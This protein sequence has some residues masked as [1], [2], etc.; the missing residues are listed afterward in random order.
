MVKKVG[1][2]KRNKRLQSNMMKPYVD[3]I[4]LSHA[5]AEANEEDLIQADNAESDAYKAN[6]RFN[7]TN[8]TTVPANI[9]R[10][11]DPSK[12][13]GVG[14]KTKT[15]NLG[16]GLQGKA[17]KG[18]LGTAKEMKKA[19]LY[20]SDG[21][22]I[23]DAD[24]SRPLKQNAFKKQQENF[25]NIARLMNTSEYYEVDPLVARNMQESDALSVTDAEFK[26]PFQR[27][28]F[29]TK[30][31]TEIGTITG[32]LI[33]RCSFYIN[34]EKDNTYTLSDKNLET[35]T[36]GKHK[37]EHTGISNHGAAE[38]CERFTWDG[39]VVAQEV[40]GYGVWYRWDY[41]GNMYIKDTLLAFPQ[42]NLAMEL[43]NDSK[44]TQI[45]KDFLVNLSFFLTIPERV[46]VEKKRD[47]K[48]RVNKG[49]A[50]IPSSTYITCNNKLKVY[51]NKY[52]QTMSE[53][54]VAIQKHR[55][56]AH[57]R[58]YTHK[59]FVNVPVVAR[60]DGSV[61]KY[62]WVR[63]SIVGSGTYIPRHRRV[64]N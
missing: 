47:V 40:D 20:G 45:I 41:D 9:G 53:G 15:V 24:I 16:H 3:F 57:W 56:K 36:C 50:P 32:I 17:P 18:F 35:C 38:G 29:S 23:S 59:K 6:K 1:K 61:G 55:R 48:R 46:F 62:V 5:L 64:K 54:G 26:L 52:E 30:L 21:K 8:I 58:K 33:N 12:L 43:V 19:D 27:C 34:K 25:L 14:G 2:R 7:N 44:A 49:R 22:K 28:F 31:K 42:D 63:P 60:P 13:I 37:Y 4:S 39:N 11:V 51:L 10:T